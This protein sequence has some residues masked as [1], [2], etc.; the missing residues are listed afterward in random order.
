M[1]AALLLAPPTLLTLLT[2]TLSSSPASPTCTALTHTLTYLAA[3][4]ASTAVYRLSPWHPL[5]RYPGPLGCKLSKLW[6]GAVC[7]PGFQ[8]KYIQALHERY[9]DVVR[10]GASCVLRLCLRHRCWVVLRE[11]CVGVRG[12]GDSARLGCDASACSYSQYPPRYWTRAGSV[13]APHAHVP[14]RA[15]THAREHSVLTTAPL[16]QART[17]SR[18]ATRPS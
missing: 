14:T 2:L 15:G 6:M 13:D 5:A 17:S 3:L 8:H 7:V 16:L 1:H 18:S 10:I 11:C 4:L 9:G 12:L